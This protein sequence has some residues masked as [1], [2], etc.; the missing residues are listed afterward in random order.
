MRANRKRSGLAHTK[1]QRHKH[2]RTQHYAH[3][4]ALAHR[5]NI[6]GWDE[7]LSQRQNYRNLGIVFDANEALPTVRKRGPAGATEIGGSGSMT[8]RLEKAQAAPKRASYQVKSMSVQEQYVKSQ[9]L[10]ITM[11][12]S[13]V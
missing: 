5:T 8:A 13:R 12:I 3:N 9:L 1:S 10:Y 6:E 2:K 4:A 11:Y 7:R